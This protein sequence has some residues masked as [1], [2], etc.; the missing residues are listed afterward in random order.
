MYRRETNLHSLC[1]YHGFA[2]HGHGI[3]RVGVSGDLPLPICLPVYGIAPGRIA[4]DRGAWFSGFSRPG[5][6]EGVDT[7]NQSIWRK[8]GIVCRIVILK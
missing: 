7:K 2:S 3:V 5:V 4:S 6:N 8:D 1:H